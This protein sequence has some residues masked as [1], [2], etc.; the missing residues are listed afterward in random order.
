MLCHVHPDHPTTG[1]NIIIIVM[2]I[3]SIRDIYNQC[4]FFRQHRKISIST[5]YLFRN[6]GVG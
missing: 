6:T 5:A 2:H 4:K 3:L 1:I